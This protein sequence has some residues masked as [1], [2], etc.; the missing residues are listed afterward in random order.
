MY[1]GKISKAKAVQLYSDMQSDAL[2]PTVWEDDVIEYVP[3]NEVRQDRIN[4]NQIIHTQNVYH[5]HHY[6]NPKGKSQVKEPVKNK[7]SDEEA[8]FWVMSILGFTFTVGFMI[9]I[10]IRG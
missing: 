2:V 10:L 5:H 4:A 1:R 3:A 6:A 7:V 8:L 9:A